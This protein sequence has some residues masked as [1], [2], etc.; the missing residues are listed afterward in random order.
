MRRM[1]AR[2][3]VDPKTGIADVEIYIEDGSKKEPVCFMPMANSVTLIND[4]RIAL[5]GQKVVEEER[6]AAG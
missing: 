5:M 2:R 4:L 1:R 3:D 6:R